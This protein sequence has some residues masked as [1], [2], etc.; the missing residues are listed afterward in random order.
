MGVWRGAG[1]G[2]ARRYG[3]QCG[4]V[5]V[6]LSNHADIVDREGREA[7]DRAL[8]V[9]ASRL[10]GVVRDVDTVCRIA[11]TRFAML[12]EGPQR[13]DQLKLLAQHVVAKG[14]ERVPTL[15][16]ELS[17]RLRLVSASSAVGR[18]RLRWWPSVAEAFSNPSNGGGVHAPITVA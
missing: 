6:D 3:H 9:T 8:V 1:G 4:L 5:L 12:I 16:M 13:P 10:S 15:P 18:R 7:G 17:L 11:D 14:L 2:G